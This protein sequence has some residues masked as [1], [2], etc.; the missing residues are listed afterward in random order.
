[1]HGHETDRIV[2]IDG[3]VR[4]VAN[5][6][7]LDVTRHARE[8]SVAAVLKAPNHGAQLL[9]VLSRLSIARST[10]FC[11]IRGFG[12]KPTQ[13][14]GRGQP[15][16]PREPSRRRTSE[17]LQHA[18]IF[19]GE[20]LESGGHVHVRNG[21]GQIGRQD[22]ESTIGQAHKSRPKQRGGAHIRLRIGKEAKKRHRVLNLVGVEETETLVDVGGDT[23]PLERLLELSMGIARSKEHCDVGRLCQPP[24]SGRPVANRRL[25]D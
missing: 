23:L 13:K 1:M 6:Q 4:L 20:L 7:S 5:S 10:G 21:I 12:K 15:V 8:R 16:D 24:H 9:Q 25:S 2:G 17:A 14:F 18:L 19:G 22:R 11:G 3:R